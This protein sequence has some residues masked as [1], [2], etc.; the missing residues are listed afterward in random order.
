[1]N[2]YENP[3]S[4]MQDYSLSI[5]DLVDDEKMYGYDGKDY[6]HAGYNLVFQRKYTKQIVM[7]FLPR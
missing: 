1:M 5:L 2:F 6:S 7:Y 4:D 3:E